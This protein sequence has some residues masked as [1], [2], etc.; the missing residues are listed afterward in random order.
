MSSSTGKTPPYVM[1]AKSREGL[2]EELRRR[3]ARGGVIAPHRAMITGRLT[4]WRLTSMVI[5]PLLLAVIT[6]F[7]LPRLAGIWSWLL[8]QLIGPLGLPGE[9]AREPATVFGL[10]V[11]MPYLTTNA[12]MPASAHFW[13]V[14]A[15]SGVALVASVLLPERFLPLR[16]FLRFAVLIQV[17]AFAVFA[18]RPATFPYDLPRY[19]LSLF[20]I[21]GAFLVL[22]PLLLGF[23]YFPFDVSWWR[24]LL[25]TT[26]SVGHIAVLIPLQVLVHAFLIHHL[27]LLVMPAMFLLWGIL[28]LLF[29]FIALYGWAMSWPDV[30]MRAML[31]GGVGATHAATDAPHRA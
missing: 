22:L 14:G 27:S 12:S 4:P 31:L 8:G 17:T 3:G 11:A 13:T 24:K 19:V 10:T 7:L 29:A 18:L 20:E 28:P 21:G 26:L 25:L 23:T 30:P 2:L 6:A 5:V 15:I 16:Y 9:V 1:L